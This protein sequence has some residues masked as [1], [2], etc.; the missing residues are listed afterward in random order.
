MSSLCGGCGSPPRLPQAGE[1]LL[2]HLCLRALQNGALG[3]LNAAREVLWEKMKRR[4]LFQFWV[5]VLKRGKVL[6]KILPAYH[7]RGGLPHPPQTLAEH[8]L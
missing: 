5:L 6:Q 2:Q 3:S 4:S 1:S 7:R 8:S